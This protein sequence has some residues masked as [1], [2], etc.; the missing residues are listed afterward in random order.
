MVQNKRNQAIQVNMSL[1]PRLRKKS[2]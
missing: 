1:A 2:L